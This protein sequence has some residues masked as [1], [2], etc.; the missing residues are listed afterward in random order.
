MIVLG[1]GSLPRLGS[2]NFSALACAGGGVAKNRGEAEGEG[3]NPLARRKCAY[4]T[5]FV[6]WREVRENERV[7]AGCKFGDRARARILVL[8]KFVKFCTAKVCE[9][10]IKWIS[11]F[12]LEHKPQRN[13]RCSL[14]GARWLVCVCVRVCVSHA[15]P[16]GHPDPAS[17]PWP[18]LRPRP[19]P[20]VLDL[21]ARDVA[22][23]NKKGGPA[24]TQKNRAIK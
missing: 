9:Q 17:R 22:R 2:I 21:A 3:R 7:C 4:A 16:T 20:M 23:P 5:L 18:E 12:A 8:V 15:R 6:Q 10:P 14:A 1:V 11:P 24:A 19:Q 13:L